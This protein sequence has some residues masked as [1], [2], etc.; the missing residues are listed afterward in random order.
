MKNHADALI[1]HTTICDGAPQIVLMYRA[2][3]A[4]LLFARTSAAALRNGRLV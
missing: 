1:F 4:T 3:T 2:K